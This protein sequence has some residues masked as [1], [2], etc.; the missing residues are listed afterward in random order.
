[1]FGFKRESA[2]TLFEE[3]VASKRVLE[4]AGFTIE[5][6]MREKRLRYER[7]HNVL[8]Y[9]ILESEHRKQ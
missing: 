1:V 8:I 6:A 9:S 2:A 7:W 4:K 5:G 3:N